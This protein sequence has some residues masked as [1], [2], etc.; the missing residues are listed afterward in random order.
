MARILSS[1]V[2][3]RPLQYID[4]PQRKSTPASRLGEVLRWCGSTF[5]RLIARYP[6]WAVYIAGIVTIFVLFSPQRGSPFAWAALVVVIAVPPLVFAFAI[7]VL[8]HAL[9]VCIAVVM[10]FW[11]A[12][13]YVL[14]GR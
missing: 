3:G 6:A 11:R 14:A 5:V 7:Q 8:A 13:R 4:G 9:S 2:G 12:V 1:D 10:I